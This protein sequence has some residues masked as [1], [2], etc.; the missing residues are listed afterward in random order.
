MSIDQEPHP[1]HERL[2]TEIAEP[3]YKAVRKSGSA[4]SAQNTLRAELYSDAWDRIKNAE[5]SNCLF[6]VVTLCDMLTTDRLEAFTQYL[7]F[8]EDKQFVTDSIGEAFKN[9]GWA[10]K[11]RGKGQGIALDAEYKQL[12]KLVSEFVSLRNRVVHGHLI[13]RNDTESTN[14]KERILLLEEAAIKG[15]VAARFVDGWTNKR[16]KI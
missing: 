10:V 4:G 2:N 8:D 14:L 15:K 9:F 5:E 6:E 16:T 12:N 11:H 7:M 1:L 3:T 13:V